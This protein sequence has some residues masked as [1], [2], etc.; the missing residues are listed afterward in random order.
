MKPTKNRCLLHCFLVSSSSRI[1]R[2]CRTLLHESAVSGKALLTLLLAS[3]NIFKAG[4]VYC[5][6]KRRDIF[7]NVFCFC[8]LFSSFFV[9]TVLMSSG[10]VVMTWCLYDTRIDSDGELDGNWACFV[11]F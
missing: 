10:D 3:E 8:G 1:M 9:Y 2:A 7:P 6:S 4:H 5:G 11:A